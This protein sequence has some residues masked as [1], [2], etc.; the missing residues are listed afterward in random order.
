MLLSQPHLNYFN[1]CPSHILLLNGKYHYYP[2]LFPSALLLKNTANLSSIFVS[3]FLIY[4]TAFFHTHFYLK[5]PPDLLSLLCSIGIWNFTQPCGHLHSL[6]Y[7]TWSWVQNSFCSPA[8][9]FTKPTSHS[10]FFS[11]VLPLLLPHCHI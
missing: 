11:F 3:F 7:L 9:S 4:T 5:L 10:A 1:K 8:P 6:C 2:I